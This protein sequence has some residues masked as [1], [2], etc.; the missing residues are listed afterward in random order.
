MRVLKCVVICWRPAK[1]EVER[2]NVMFARLRQKM[3]KRMKRLSVW[4]RTTSLWQSTVLS[5]SRRREVSLESGVGKSYGWLWIIINH[6]PNWMKPLEMQSPLKTLGP[7]VAI[8]SCF[9]DFR[10]SEPRV[11]VGNSSSLRNDC[12]W[13][14][15]LARCIQDSVIVQEHDVCRE[16][17]HL[18]CRWWRTSASTKGGALGVCIP[19]KLT[20]SARTISTVSP[21]S[22]PAK[23]RPAWFL[24][25]TSTGETLLP[26]RTLRI[27]VSFIRSGI[28]ITDLELKTTALSAPRCP[29]GRAAQTP[30]YPLS[31]QW[32]FS[33]DRPD[34][35]TY[36]FVQSTSSPATWHQAP[37]R[38]CLFEAPSS[39][40][41]GPNISL[42]VAKTASMV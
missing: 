13:L 40:L 20:L 3:V 10:S 32:K 39:Q 5:K 21:W 28:V 15:Q 14:L 34:S 23:V 8:T 16:S 42:C 4:E 30:I 37:G 38:G 1:G 17:W 9:H 27:L 24:L 7:L 11:W 26:S 31:I 35:S 12:H 2:K 25:F 36:G 6:G 33:V 29:L 41:P 19:A 18:C 22:P